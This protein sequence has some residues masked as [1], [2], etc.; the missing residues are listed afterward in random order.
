VNAVELP[1]ELVKAIVL[2]SG[3]SWGDATPEDRQFFSRF[4]GLVA[5]VEREKANKQSQVEINH[6]KEQLMRSNTHDGAYKA[7]FLAGQM[8]AR[9]GK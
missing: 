6:L 7:A 1:D 9:G 4:A 8:A 3:G 2:K 5:A